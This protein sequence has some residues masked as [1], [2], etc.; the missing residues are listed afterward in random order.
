MH[1][2]SQIKVT[3]CVMTY[4]HENYIRECLDSILSQV[5]NFQFK[6]F[7]SDDC[8]SDNTFEVLKEYASKHANI[9]IFSRCGLSKSYVNGKP[10]GNMNFIETL[11]KVKSEYT[12]YCDGDDVWATPLKLQKQID[13]LESSSDVALTCSSR[14]SIVNGQSIKR[15]SFLPDMK[16]S[17]WWLCF[18]NPLPASSVAFKTKYLV[19]PPS[20]FINKMDIGDWPIWF[21]ISY[22]KKIYKFS[23]A[24][25]DYRVHPEGAWSRKKSSEKVTTYLDTIKY[26]N[27]YHNHPFFYVSYFL[28]YLR[29]KLCKLFE[30]LK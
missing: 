12:A 15:S 13:V 23:S 26:L 17:Y 9:E 5:T 8:S 2:S 30:A 11:K 6:I 28:H 3:V 4:N 1:D 16:I 7:V 18:F 29:F 20:W 22:K 10:T 19:E 25:L 24:L 27:S 21:L 14:S